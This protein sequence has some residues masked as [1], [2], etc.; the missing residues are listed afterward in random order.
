M[1]ACGPCCRW[2]YQTAFKVESCCPWPPAG[3]YAP[4][5]PG[6]RSVRSS[7]PPSGLTSVR[8]TFPS[9]V[10]MRVHSHQADRAHA[11]RAPGHAEGR[12]SDAAGIDRTG[13]LGDGRT[14]QLGRRTSYRKSRSI[15]RAASPLRPGVTWL[16]V[17]SVRAT[18]LWP[19]RCWTSFGCTPASRS[20]VAV[21]C[22][23]S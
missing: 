1:P 23:R 16:Y 8:G 18:V 5:S 2:P 19:S 15:V 7:R 12:G 11:T 20:T 9:G 17:F 14:D 4:D 22:L 6:Q 10:A 13:D 3:A 21:V